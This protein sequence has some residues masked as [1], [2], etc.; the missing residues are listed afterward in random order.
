[1]RDIKKPLGITLITIGM[2]L[3]A[4]PMVK[5][6][7]ATYFQRISLAALEEPFETEAKPEPGRDELPVNSHEQQEPPEPPDELPAIN[8][9]LEIPKINVRAVVVQGVTE[10]HLKQGPGFYPQSKY[11]QTGNV[12]IAAHR[13]VYG[14]WFRNV[15]KLDPG[16][17]IV[18][19]LGSKLYRYTVREQFVT[20]SR[21]WSVVESTGNPELT[22]TTCLFT[23]TTKRLIVKA[24]LKEIEKAPEPQRLNNK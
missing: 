2:L 24:D 3:A 9:I 20:H 7:Q 12:S 5:Y 22:L 13:G 10:E 8:G 11:P 15:N 17:E 6:G 21:D 19:T 23:T 16:D 4:I 1:M 18:L 14:A